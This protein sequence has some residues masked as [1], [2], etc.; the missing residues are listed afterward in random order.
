MHKDGEAWGKTSRPGA[1]DVL[2]ISGR[3]LPAVGTKKAGHSRPPFGWE[4]RVLRMYGF[5]DRVRGFM[6]EDSALSRCWKH[7]EDLLSSLFG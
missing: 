1:K 5:G 2:G 3:T 7:V 4:L 6:V